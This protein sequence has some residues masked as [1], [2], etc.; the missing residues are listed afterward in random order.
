MPP[1]RLVY[2]AVK[3]ELG[4]ALAGMQKPI[5]VAATGAMK[6]AAAQIKTR[7]RA[8]IAAAG[9]SSKWQNALQVNV[10]P[11]HGVAL[12]PALWAYHKIK[13]AGVFETGAVITG[14]PF[15]WLPIAALPSKIG[16]SRMTPR[17]YQQIVGPLRSI[18]VPGKAP[19]L[20]GPVRGGQA[21]SQL[22]LS[23][24]RAGVRG[25]KGVE[26]MP[27]FI[28][29]RSVTE[30]PR[31]GLQAVFDTAASGLAAGYLAHLK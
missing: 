2:T 12:D 19:M 6:D 9:F 17:L 30:R 24:L 3:G 8:N 15:L 21:G 11:Q 22:T 10:Y 5:A 18:R 26:T 29:I 7:G 14:K 4:D 27:L 25:G 13:Y 1:L 28:G 31:F 16:S 20:V 23:K